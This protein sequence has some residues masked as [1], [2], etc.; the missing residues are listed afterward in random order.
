[1]IKK[2]HKGGNRLK[3]WLQ[4]QPSPNAEMTSLWSVD[5]PPSLSMT[6]FLLLS[7]WQ[8]ERAK[9]ACGGERRL[10][11]AFPLLRSLLGLPLSL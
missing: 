5:Q 11:P 10:V 6:C 8:S 4:L 9:V 7:Q 2:N 3:T 1:M